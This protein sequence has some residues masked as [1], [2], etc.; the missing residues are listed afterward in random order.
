MDIKTEQRRAFIINT[1]YLALAAAMVILGF[2]YVVPL[3]LPFII[4]YAIAILFKP[5]VQF[6]VKH[7]KVGPKFAGCVVLLLA[8]VL[9]ASLLFL[10]GVKIAGVLGDFFSG[11]P[12]AY[13]NTIQP[14]ILAVSEFFNNLLGPLLPEVVGSGNEV[15]SVTLKDLQGTLLS[16]S[17]AALTGLGAITAKVPTFLLAFFFTIM[18]SLIISMNYAQISGFLAK[19]V[20]ERY[21]EIL[22]QV[23]SGALQTV[24]NYIIAYLKL[25]GITFVELAVGLAFLRVE[26]AVLVALGIA[27]FD[28]LPVLGT[29][30]VMIPWI[31]IT[32]I[33]MNF[34]LAA[35][36]AVLYA[37]VTVIRNIIEPRIVGNQLGLHPLVT[38]C[39]IYVGFKIMGVL[40]MIVFPILVQVVMG[41]H[42]SGVITL[43]KRAEEPAPADGDNP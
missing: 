7:S 16:F 6:V 18:S 19:Q 34:P 17:T 22:F 36:L 5:I 10:G 43:W 28:A 40:G 4:G 38:L 35:G 25:M 2:K 26:N 37:I 31:L 21:R 24:G 32:L 8:Y 33:N 41:L 29:G 12:A 15:L 13:E 20:P 23:K 9:I 11:L 1:V 27:V 14:A 39:A 30:G 3:L 42:R